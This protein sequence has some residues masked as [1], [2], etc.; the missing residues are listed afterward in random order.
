MKPAIEV[1]IEYIDELFGENGAESFVQLA[2]H[3]NKLIVQA[4]QMKQ[5][6]HM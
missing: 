1:S 2:K 6:H 5:A 4:V 3:T